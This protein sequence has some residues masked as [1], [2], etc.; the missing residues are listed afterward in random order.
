MDKIFETSFM[1]FRA[2]LYKDR[3]TYKSWGMEQTIF[4][5]QIA[6]VDTGVPGV[7][8]IKVESAGGKVHKIVVRLRDKTK[9]KEAI[10]A[11]KSEMVN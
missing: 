11:A 3:L 7:Q 1:G 6:S 4:L 10:Y 5:N 9:L 8:Q 2:V